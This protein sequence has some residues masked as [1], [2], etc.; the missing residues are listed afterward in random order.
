[1]PLLPPFQTHHKTTLGKRRNA[2]PEHTP[3][4]KHHNINSYLQD[5]IIIR[6]TK[7]MKETLFNCQ[8]LQEKQL[9][10]HKDMLS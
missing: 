7:F 3:N 1:M 4:I 5:Y 10:T 6:K 2:S 8:L 9:A